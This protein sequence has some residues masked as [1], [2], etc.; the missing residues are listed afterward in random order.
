[1]GG[2]L[3]TGGGF[4]LLWLQFYGMAAVIIWTVVTSSVMFLALKAIGK[5]RISDSAMEMGID[6]YEHGATV[7]PD[8][9]DID[10]EK[11]GVATGD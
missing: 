1:M 6:V 7:W 8:V 10:T 11:G 4:G 3:F 9:L 5:L 2:G